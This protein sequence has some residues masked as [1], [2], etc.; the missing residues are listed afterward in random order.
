MPYAWSSNADPNNAVA[1]TGLSR[2]AADE[3]ACGNG[4]A[5]NRTCILD[6]AIESASVGQQTV[7][8]GDYTNSTSTASTLF[9]WTLPVTSVAKNYRYSCD[10][11]WESTAATVTGP[12]WGVNLS[13]APTQLTAMSETE[14]GLAG[15][16]INGY[17]SNTTTGHQNLGVGTAGGVTTTNYRAKIWGTIEGAAAAGSTFIIDAAALSSV[18]STLNVRRGS[19]C[20]LTASN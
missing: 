7:T 10:I 5:A 1:D 3:V 9:S 14:I 18:T 15:T 19:G 6:V 4:T 20:L 11:M 16:D 12:Q 13:A 8:G 2:V 17:L